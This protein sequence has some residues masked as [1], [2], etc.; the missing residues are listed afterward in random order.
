[1]FLKC[2]I[3]KW[4]WYFVPVKHKKLWHLRISHRMKIPRDQLQAWSLSLQV[5]VMIHFKGYLLVFTAEKFFMNMNW[6]SL[7]KNHH[8]NNNNVNSLLLQQ[9]FY[10]S[11]KLCLLHIPY[12]AKLRFLS[13][14][15]TKAGI[16]KVLTL[17]FCTY[18]NRIVPVTLVNHPL[19][20]AK[21]MNRGKRLTYRNQDNS[22][23][24]FTAQQSMIVKY[25]WSSSL[26]KHFK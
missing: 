9:Y 26:P 11:L 8:K 17:Q 1:M 4:D 22:H 10:C 23:A 25:S 12:A 7:G 15:P 16:L 19:T 2:S 18:V 20:A 3:L 21:G 6:K 5:A 14:K 24:I 13:R